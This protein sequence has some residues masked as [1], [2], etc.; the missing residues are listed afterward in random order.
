MV[1]SLESQETRAGDNPINKF[2]LKKINYSYLLD[3]ELL[4]LDL[5][6]KID[7]PKFSYRWEF[8]TK[9]VILRQNLFKGLPSGLKLVLPPFRKESGLTLI[10]F[11]RK[12][13]YLNI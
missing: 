2:C 1:S 10:V 3:C 7:D 11:R 9:L 13:T 5:S 8:K 12:I 6:N 4:N